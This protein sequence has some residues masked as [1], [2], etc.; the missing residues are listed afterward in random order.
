M[1]KEDVCE[2]YLKL[3]NI[4]KILKMIYDKCDLEVIEKEMNINFR[5][6]EGLKN[7]FYRLVDNDEIEDCLEFV[8]NYF[9]DAIKESKGN[10]MDKKVWSLNSFLVSFF[11]AVENFPYIS[12]KGRQYV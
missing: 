6:N 4:R 12:R 3:Y 8:N 10:L 11:L 7:T 5:R 9:E 2:Y 1:S